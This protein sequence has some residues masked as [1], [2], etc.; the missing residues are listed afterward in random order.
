MCIYGKYLFV[1]KKHHDQREREIWKDIRWYE[2]LYKVSNLWN[3]FSTWKNRLLKTPIDPYWYPR[4]CLK[5]KVYKVHRLVAM[6]FINNPH[7]K[8][9]VNHKDGVKNNNKIDNLE[10]N[11][12]WENQ[13]H[14]YRT[15]W[16]KPAFL[17]VF[18]KDNPT[19][20]KIKQLNLDWKII[21]VWNAMADVQ[22]ELWIFKTHISACCLWKENTAWWYK[23]EYE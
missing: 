11:T 9:T 23:W 18:W 1:L 6:A 12:D 8:R 7:N 13:T 5:G 15:L 22:R 4:V 20:K 16:R 19:S 3:I 10:W 21:R 2:W 17:W 14:G